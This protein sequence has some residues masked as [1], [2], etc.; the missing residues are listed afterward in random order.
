[1]FAVEL[2]IDVGGFKVFAGPTFRLRDLESEEL[3]IFDDILWQE[4]RIQ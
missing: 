4:V 3:D 1:M 2:E